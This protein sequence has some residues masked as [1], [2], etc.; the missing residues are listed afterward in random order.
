M[1]YKDK[2]GAGMNTN[3]KVGVSTNHVIAV[4]GKV[5]GNVKYIVDAGNTKENLM[6]KRKFQ[7]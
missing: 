1:H 7:Y 4:D 3:L 6:E 2:R 5:S